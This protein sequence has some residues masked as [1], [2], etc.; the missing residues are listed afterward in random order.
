MYIPSWPAP[1]NKKLPGG[2]YALAF[3]IIPK[4]AGK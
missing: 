2:G 1:V 3:I 4:D